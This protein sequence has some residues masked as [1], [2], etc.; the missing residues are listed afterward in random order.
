M[1][2]IQIPVEGMTCGG[3]VASV[4]RALGRVEGVSEATATLSPGSV[5]V[6]FDAA[7]VDLERLVS[8]IDDAGYSV[9]EVW[10]TERR[11]AASMRS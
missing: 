2:Q 8:V 6:T 11:E 9:P 7:A 3:C 10:L 1:Q 5:A 4:Q